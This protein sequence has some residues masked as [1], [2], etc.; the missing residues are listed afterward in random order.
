MEY[1]IIN[2]NNEFFKKVFD[3]VGIEFDRKF[4]T[5]SNDDIDELVKAIRQEAISTKGKELIFINKDENEFPSIGMDFKLGW[6]TIICY[7]EEEGCCYT[8]YN[9]KYE[10]SQKNAVV[11]IGGQSPVEEKFTLDNLED[12]I[13]FITY[14]IEHKKFPNTFV[15]AKTTW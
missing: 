7:D 6:S 15:W 12:A 9:P 11:E 2:V 3:I 8:V 14:I 1:E 4:Y 13:H 5:F 10:D